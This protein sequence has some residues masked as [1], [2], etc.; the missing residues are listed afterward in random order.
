MDLGSSVW[1]G[2][3]GG[4]RAVYRVHRA[5]GAA[6]GAGGIWKHEHAEPADFSRRVLERVAIGDHF[7]GGGGDAHTRWLWPGVLPAAAAARVGS[8]GPGADRVLRGGS[9]AGIACGLGGGHSSRRYDRSTLLGN[10]QRRHF[11]LQPPRPD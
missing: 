11:H 4:L 8:D 5:L 6:I 1:T 9:I 2:G 7:A 10:D 3:H